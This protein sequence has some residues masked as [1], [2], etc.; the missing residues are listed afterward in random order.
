VRGS[1]L[2][3]DAERSETRT[4]SCPRPRERPGRDSFGTKGRVLMA[5]VLPRRSSTATGRTA[6]VVIVLAALAGALVLWMVLRPGS[7]PAD[8]RVQPIGAADITVINP[9][10][11]T[12]A[13]VVTNHGAA[14]ATPTCEVDA[15][16]VDGSHHGTGQFQ[17]AHPLDPGRSITFTAQ[18]AI[19]GLG[20][21]TV[22]QA[23]AHCA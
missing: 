15:E 20:A 6:S 3:G 10:D 9:A 23:S 2:Q 4:A 5:A 8:L 13:V 18:L 7:P 22:T 21:Q 1:A 14:Q 11:V 17:L 16:N 19:S 12:V